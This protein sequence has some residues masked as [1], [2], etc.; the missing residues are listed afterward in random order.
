M[1]ECP[2]TKDVTVF[3]T[4][5]EEKTAML[6]NPRCKQWG[7]DF[8]AELNKD[9]W[10]YQASRGATILTMEGQS[11]QFVTLTSRGYTTPHQSIYFFKTNWPKLRKRMSSHTN[12][13]TPF[14]GVQWAYFLVPERHKSGVLH[15]HLIAATHVTGESFWKHH[16]YKSG[17]GYILDVQE[18]IDA[19]SVAT[20]VAKYL[21]KDGGSLNWPKG[22]RHI[23]HS[24]NWPIASIQPLEGWDWKTYRKRETIW[25]EKHALIDMGWHVIDKTKEPL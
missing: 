8:C 13:W 16:A 6:F 19:L 5:A 17:F 2:N 9:F 11:L 10:I 21:H 4:N 12:S 25:T 23:R 15:A 20:Y 7:C 1:K 24:Q 22:F 3:G 14:T 18:N